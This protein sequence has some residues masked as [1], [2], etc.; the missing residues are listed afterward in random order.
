M[1]WDHIGGH[2]ARE[3]RLARGASRRNDEIITCYDDEGR[4][5]CTHTYKNI[6]GRPLSALLVQWPEEGV[7]RRL[8]ERRG[9]E[10]KLTISTHIYV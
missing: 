10:K 5:P 9:G 3:K 4:R 1:T 8:D 7:V 6:Y 2:G